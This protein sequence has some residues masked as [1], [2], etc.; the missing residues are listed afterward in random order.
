MERD[1]KGNGR[2]LTIEEGVSGRGIEEEE[3]EEDEG[4]TG[5]NDRGEE[6]EE[7]EEEEEKKEEEEK[8]EEEKEEEEEEE[9]ST[10]LFRLILGVVK[11]FILTQ[12][13]GSPPMLLLSLTLLFVIGVCSDNG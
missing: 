9:E 12:V 1:V 5:D 13:N 11:P 2:K 6:E 4:D 3:E 10:I 8:E 7:Q